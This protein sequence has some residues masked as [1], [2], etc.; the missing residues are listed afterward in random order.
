MDDA[1]EHERHLHQVYRQKERVYWSARI[2]GQAKQ[3]RQLWRPVN[4]LLD[5]SDNTTLPKNCP[6]AQKFAD[7]FRR[8]LQWCAKQR[9][10]V[11]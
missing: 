10:V 1:D 4:M 11:M 7:F 3:P 6:P 9:L 5:A 2:C 8:K